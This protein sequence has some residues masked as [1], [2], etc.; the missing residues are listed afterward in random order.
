MNDIPPFTWP[1]RLPLWLSW[2][3]L[4]ILTA[5]CGRWSRCS[6]THAEDC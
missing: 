3:A 5:V 1:M 6:R 4:W 2:A